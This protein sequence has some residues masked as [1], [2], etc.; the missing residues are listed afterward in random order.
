MPR[1]RAKAPCR[2]LPQNYVNPLILCHKRSVLTHVRSLHVGITVRVV[3]SKQSAK[4][5]GIMALAAAAYAVC[6][7]S[8]WPLAS[9]CKRMVCKTE[10]HETGSNEMKDG[11]SPNNVAYS[12]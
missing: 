11:V 2:F 12:L 7:G 3:S 5:N 8:D 9:V 6:S 4:C 10:V 1:L